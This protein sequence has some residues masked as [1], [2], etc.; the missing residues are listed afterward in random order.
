M[1]KGLGKNEMIPTIVFLAFLLRIINLNQGF[2]LDEAISALV[3]KNYSFFGIIKDFLPGDTHPP[4]YYLLL[5][6]WSMVFGYGEVPLRILSVFFGV[7][8]LYI[9]Y[10][11]G[12]KL[13]DKKTGIIASIMLATSPLHIYYSQEVRMYALSTLTI[14]VLL[15]SYIVLE[16]GTYARN[17]IVFSLT[18][19]FIGLTDYLPLLI[20]P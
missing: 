1:G 11:I 10:L 15:Y 3:V 8:T 20:I 17:W 19:L 12:V 4:F 9:V 7:S 18:L 5:K 14:A 6:I 13:V 16:R 2:W